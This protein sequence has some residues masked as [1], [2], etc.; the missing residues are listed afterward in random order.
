MHGNYDNNNICLKNPN[1]LFETI[2]ERERQV[3]GGGERE[4]EKEFTNC[5]SYTKCLFKCI[6][7]KGLTFQSYIAR[8]SSKA[9]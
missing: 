5:L 8:C 2:S 9:N 1:C 6:N 4:V 3:G 7:L